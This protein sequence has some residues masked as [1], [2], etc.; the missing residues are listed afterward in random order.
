MSLNRT[1]SGPAE[2]LKLMAKWVLLLE[3]MFP[4]KQFCHDNTKLKPK[5]WCLRSAFSVGL[6]SLTSMVSLVPQY[7]CHIDQWLVLYLRAQ[8]K[9]TYHEMGKVHWGWP[10]LQSLQAL[11]SLR[12]LSSWFSL[13]FTFFSRYHMASF[14]TSFKSL[15]K[16]HSIKSLMNKV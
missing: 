5:V 2:E 14:L 13:L 9:A 10:S 3:K 1:K 4:A 16:C 7:C 12:G 8:S 11:A 6:V 15:L